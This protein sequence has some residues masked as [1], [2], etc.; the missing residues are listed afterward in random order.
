M[1]EPGLQGVLGVYWVEADAM[2]FSN[3][4]SSRPLMGPK[5][6]NRVSTN[7]NS[8]SLKLGMFGAACDSNRSVDSCCLLM[9][10]VECVERALM[11]SANLRSIVA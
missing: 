7:S 9:S 4:C 1:V 6:G 11:S 8:G 10:G 3:R 2:Y 5:V